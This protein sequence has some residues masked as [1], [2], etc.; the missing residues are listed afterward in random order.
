MYTS[1]VMVKAVIDVGSNSVLLLVAEK[2][3]DTWH[4]ILESTHV[5]GIGRDTKNTGM[6]HPAGMIKTLEALKVCFEKAYSAGAT[7]VRAAGTM[8]LRI[9]QNSPEFLRDCDKQQTPVEI[10]SGEME[11]DLS[12]LSISNDPLFQES[13][14]LTM[15]DVGGQ[16]T[17]IATARRQNGSWTFEFRESFSIGALGLRETEFRNPSPSFADRLRALETID[18]AIGIRY[19]PHRSGKVVT[20]GATGTNLISIREKLA[21]WDANHV[22]GQ[23]LDYEEVS[24]AVSMLCDLD[25]IGRRNVIG[26]EPGREFTLHAGALILERAL[27]ALG[28]HECWVS[29]RGWRFAYLQKCFS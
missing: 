21:N 12:F 13:P 29:V 10:I 28:A 4:P 20:V 24:K 25:D 19:L 22:H 23:L 3:F 17:E 1:F 7:E 27:F 26:I 9:A 16:S 11:A 18:E 5:T 6:L 8:A 14:V 15:I 2:R